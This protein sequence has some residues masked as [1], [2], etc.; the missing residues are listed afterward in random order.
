MNSE[1]EHTIRPK[2]SHEVRQS[3]VD[4]AKKKLDAGCTV[5]A[6]GYIQLAAKNG[7]TRLDFIKVGLGTFA[8]AV[9]ASSGFGIFGLLDAK[10]AKA[11]DYWCIPLDGYCDGGD[12]C[13]V[14]Q[15]WWNG[16][17]WFE[18]QCFPECC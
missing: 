3:A 16:E 5:C 14:Y 13:E 8:A 12:W 2:P 7:A 10:P 11:D 15:C 6:K 1:P 4:M 9:L 17:T 18:V